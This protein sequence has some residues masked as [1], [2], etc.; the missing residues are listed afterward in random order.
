MKIIYIFIILFILAVAEIY[1][2]NCRFERFVECGHIRG[3]FTQ[4][5]GKAFPSNEKELKRQ[6]EL[7]EEMRNCIYNFSQNCLTSMDII[8]G[9]S[10]VSEA[11]KKM[12][13]YCNPE[14]QLFKE[15]LKEAECIND[16]YETTKLCFKDTLDSAIAAYRST[17]KNKLFIY[18]CGVNR[19]RKCINDHYEDKCNKKAASLM[20]DQLEM[21]F[22]EWTYAMCD[23]Y[24]EVIKDC[25]PKPM[26][27]DRDKYKHYYFIRYLWP[28]S[29]FN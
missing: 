18:C 6:C 5:Y 10:M 2:L 4:E 3:R 9:D 27:I 16:N 28:F 24:L 14:K 7:L 21:I 23:S 11:V 1:A 17:S 22:T 29:E 19:M 13:D 15:Y 20:A 26:L 12:K 25:P 8:I